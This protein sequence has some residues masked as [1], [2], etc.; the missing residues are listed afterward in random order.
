MS[1]YQKVLMKE[2]KHPLQNHARKKLEERGIVVEEG[3]NAN[4]LNQLELLKENK[5]PLQIYATESL[6]KRKIDVK[7][8]ESAISI[9]L[10]VL[11]KEGKLSLQNLTAAQIENRSNSIS[12]SKTKEGSNT[13]VKWNKNLKAFIEFDG[14]PKR[15][16][17]EG[18][19][20]DNQRTNLR[21]MAEK[22]S[23]QTI[24]QN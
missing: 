20:L 3:E 13:Q 7:E 2:N 10:R 15:S 6:K 23:M 12:K 17:P 1:L 22:E 11:A 19:W 4:S 16:D 24:L 18:K 5:H 14:I 9:N 8:G 21:N